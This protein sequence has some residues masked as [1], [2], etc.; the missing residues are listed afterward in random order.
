MRM[1]VCSNCLCACCTAQ[2]NVRSHTSNKND[3]VITMIVLM[4]VQCYNNRLAS[5]EQPLLFEADVLNAGEVFL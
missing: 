2:N 1:F 5:E 3:M 4:V